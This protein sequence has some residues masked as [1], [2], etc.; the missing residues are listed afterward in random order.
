[1]FQKNHNP[2][3]VRLILMS[4]WLG[5]TTAHASELTLQTA[6]KNTL[7]QHPKMQAF[8]LSLKAQTAQTLQAGIAPNPMLEVTANNLIA[9]NQNSLFDQTEIGIMLSQAIDLNDK[10]SAAKQLS[11]FTAKE[12]SQKQIL[13]ELE[14]S[15]ETAKKYFYALSFQHRIELLD[16]HIAQQKL[17][18]EAIQ[19]LAKA[20]I[21]PEAD[22][23]QLELQ[24]LKYQLEKQT[25]IQQQKQSRQVLSALWLSTPDFDQLT[26]NFIQSLPLP[27]LNSLLAATDATPKIMVLHAQKKIADQ[28]LNYWKKQNQ[29]DVTFGVGTHF[30]KRDIGIQAMVQMPLTFKESQQGNIQQAQTKI[31][32]AS[33]DIALAK[34]TLRLFLQQKWAEIQALK[35]QK[36]TVEV[37]LLPKATQFL[38]AAKQSYQNGGY[39]V[40]QLTQAQSQPYLFKKQLIELQIQIHQNLVDLEQITG[41]PMQHQSNHMET[42]S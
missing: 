27:P 33:L 22:V 1:M 19:P 5:F 32:A 23:A 16:H 9:S 26:G 2:I 21:V 4:L 14:L 29:S 31:E 35:Q 17:A 8:P 11:Q 13:T 30:T 37:L 28:S 10:R 15:A 42:P 39:S 12:L 24:I 38:N 18:I 6:I 25:L 3:A 36:K 41:Q 34:Q 7:E 20:S 40:L